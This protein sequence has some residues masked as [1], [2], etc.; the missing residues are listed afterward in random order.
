MSEQIIQKLQEI[1]ERRGGEMS[2]LEKE[3]YVHLFSQWEKSR[4]QETRDFLTRVLGYAKKYPNFRPSKA[5]IE[6]LLRAV[7]KLEIG[8][9]S[10]NIASKIEITRINGRSDL[11]DHSGIKTFEIAQNLPIKIEG[12][13][14]GN[15][16]INIAWSI[17]PV[18]KSYI[19]L[20]SGNMETRGNIELKNVKDEKKFE[21]AIEALYP[22]EYIFRVKANPTDLMNHPQDE[23]WIN[24]TKAQARSGERKILT[25]E[26]IDQILSTLPRRDA[27]KSSITKEPSIAITKP[28]NGDVFFINS[29]LKLEAQIEGNIPPFGYN[30]I[31]LEIMPGNN[32]K[33]IDTSST[34][35]EFIPTIQTS[36]P[37]SR[38][39]VG[40]H[41]IEIATD[42]NLP[43]G[44]L[45]HSDIITIT[46]T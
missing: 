24:V 26:E 35:K 21:Y 32:R 20:T 15:G 19:E 34:E 8:Q 25:E 42:I 38:L 44:Q 39:G 2:K 29:F 27:G 28:E 4:L 16:N 30:Y 46:I 3:F 11:I 5:L 31:W 1:V 22:G 43:T 17:S 10:R 18:E 33:R 13:V 36:I 37:A 40:S 6:K 7:E 9:K 14:Y 12:V 23:I 45:L 41:Q